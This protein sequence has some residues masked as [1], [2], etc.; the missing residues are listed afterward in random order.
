MG[1][2][3]WQQ[4]SAGGGDQRKRQ[5]SYESEK[6]LGNSQSRHE[7][8]MARRYDFGELTENNRGLKRVC[9]VAI[10]GWVVTA[11]RREIA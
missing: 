5:P 9:H 3:H 4:R 11:G 6:R 1:S 2:A 10:D 7:E 8:Q